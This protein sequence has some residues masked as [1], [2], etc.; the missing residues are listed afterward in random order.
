M[1]VQ[2][3]LLWLNVSPS[4]QSLHQPL[5]RKLA[6]YCTVAQWKYQQNPDEPSCLDIPV[7]LL[8]DYLKTSH[9]PVHLAGHGLAGLVGW[10]YAKRHPERVRSLTL[11]AVGANLAVDWQAH[12][13]AQRQLLRCSR[14]LL[15]A[16]MAYHLFGS[17]NRRQNKG[18]S[19]M[20]EWDL[21]NS[22]SPHSLLGHFS[23]SAEAIRV[24][25]LVCGSEDDVAI[26]PSH[27]RQWQQFMKPSDRLWV[28]AAGRHFFHYFYPTDVTH[29]MLDFWQMASQVA[30]DRAE[31]C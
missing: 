24:P 22:P 2:P 6:R 27:L 4:L 29:Q 18:L 30:F 19:Q 23:L 13:Y 8:H 9:R 16:Q 28:S 20:L 25:L 15:L 1:H 31:A 10:L 17:E 21:D 26:D 11:L 3:D 12:Y 7:T 14:S 5:L